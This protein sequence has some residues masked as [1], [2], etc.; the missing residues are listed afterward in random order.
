MSNIASGSERMKTKKK[1]KKHCVCSKKVMA[2]STRE[3]S[4]K[5][6]GW[7]SVV[8]EIGDGGTEHWPQH[9]EFWQQREE[10]SLEIS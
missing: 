10:K 2:T 3:I 9:G 4:I 7:K 8:K 6:W 1:K 5:L